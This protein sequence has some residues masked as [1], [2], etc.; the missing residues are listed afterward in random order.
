[1]C[2]ENSFKSKAVHSVSSKKFFRGTLCLEFLVFK[3]IC[4]LFFFLV[5]LLY[6]NYS[7]VRYKI[8]KWY[9]LSWR[10][11]LA[12]FSLLEWNVAMEKSEACL[13]FFFHFWVTWSCSFF[14]FLTFI[15]MET[16]FHWDL[17]ICSFLFLFVAVILSFFS[18]LILSIDRS[19]AG[20]FL[21]IHHW[22][23]NVS[24][25]SDI[26]RRL[27]SEE[28]WAMLPWSWVAGIFFMYGVFYTGF[29]SILALFL[30]RKSVV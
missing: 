20:S 28:T 13:I 25:R 6:L 14:S 10:F 7:F 15:S 9:F 29:V 16:C 26:C 1:M 3:V 23:T 18:P 22:R 24:L 11:S 5:F 17:F 27:M 2:S 8:V 4:L 12:L 30:D 19:H 21:V